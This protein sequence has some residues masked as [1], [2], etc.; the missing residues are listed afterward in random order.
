[1]KLLALLAVLCVTVTG[2]TK[3]PG[4]VVQDAAATT[5]APV[6]A[7]GLQCSNPE[8]IKA[9][10]AAAGEKIG[11]CKSSAAQSFGGEACKLVTGALVESL[12]GNIPAEWGCTATDAKAKLVDLVKVQCDKL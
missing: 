11:L 5:L 7:T 3:S 4:C 8:A 6:I 12:A 2:C 10:I 1:M 9:S